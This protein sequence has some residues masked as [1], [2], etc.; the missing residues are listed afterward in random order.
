MLRPDRAVRFARPVAAAALFVVFSMSCAVYAHAQMSP[1]SV[2][3]TVSTQDGSVLLPGAVVTLTA[4]DSRVLATASSDEQGRTRFADLA[5]GRY[6]LAGSLEGFTD[7]RVPVTV[8][9]G[10]DTA[11][12]IDL[13]VAGVAERVDVVSTAEPVRPTIATTLTPKT[14]LESRTI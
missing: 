12:R 6:F 2:T 10:R 13:P 9:P 11:I 4:A 7:T 3:V 14:T 1:A 8:Q 5:P